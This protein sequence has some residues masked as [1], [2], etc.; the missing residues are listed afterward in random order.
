[1]SNCLDL[2]FSR[3][4]KDSF[5]CFVAFE[6]YKSTFVAETICPDPPCKACGLSVYK[7]SL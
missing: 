4:S 5:T 6:I 7:I 2:T 3:L 1:M